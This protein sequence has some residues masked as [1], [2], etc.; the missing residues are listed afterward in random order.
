MAESTCRLSNDQLVNLV[1]NGDVAT[2]SQALRDGAD[3]NAADNQLITL[4][5]Y[6]ALT[7]NLEVGRLLLDTG[8]CDVGRVNSSGWNALHCAAMEG[9]VYM[10]KLLLDA[11]LDVNSRTFYDDTPLLTAVSRGHLDAVKA[12]IAAGADV[13]VQNISGA[14]ALGHATDCGFCNI[15]AA[16][17]D[18]PAGLDVNTSDVSSGCTALIA[19][20]QCVHPAAVE[21][22]LSRG[23]D[24]NIPDVCGFTALYWAM[25]SKEPEAQLV[26]EALKRA[27][28]RGAP[29]E[30]VLLKVLA[31][32]QRNMDF[33]VGA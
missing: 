21:L 7:G 15:I 23:A 8:R 14:T 9:H 27:G 18:A 16:L 11:G 25:R 4:L 28:G 19:A 32:E 29:P 30:G 24:P 17:L 3:P 31:D 26:I 13:G 6:A 12:L 10:I 1:V 33:K 5:M 2:L 20:A 22:L